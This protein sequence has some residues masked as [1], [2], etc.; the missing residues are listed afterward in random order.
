MKTKQ[1]LLAAF[2]IFCATLPALAQDIAP[3]EARRRAT[4]QRIHDRAVTLDAHV[5]IA[6]TRYATD[7]LDPGIDHPELKCDL[8]KMKRG[9]VDG[10]FLAVWTRQ[11]RLDAAGY[12][13][14]W[15]TAVQQFDAI[16]RLTDRLYPE[17]CELATSPADVLRIARSGK[18]AVMIGVENGY[19]IGTDLAKLEKLY[20]M[21]ARY[22]TLCHC[23][24]NQICDSLDA[25]QELGDKEQ[26]YHGLSAFGER[27]VAKMNRLGMM[28][29]V[30]HVSRESFYDA[31]KSSKAPVIATHVGARACFDTPRNL[32]DRQLKALAAHGGVIQIYVVGSFLKT[33]TPERQQAVSD[34]LERIGLPVKDGEPDYVNC[35]ENEIAQY[36][37]GIRVVDRQTPAAEMDDFM[38]HIDHVVAV[39]GIDHVGIGTDFD[40]GGDG[41][42]GFE[43]HSE[44]LNVTVELLRRG[45]SE[46]QVEKIWGGN[47][48]RVWR[49]VEAAAKRQPTREERIR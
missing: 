22:M 18:R 27:V 29:D 24:H 25:N 19:P 42:R 13:E 16:H 26:A 37:R 4:A 35:T 3:A 28:I 41:V 5:D 2:F 43:N 48:L 23:G 36:D 11:Q 34:L 15:R 33:P 8:V 12:R 21:G 17:R 47:L 30:S 39:A 40:G 45:Y 9:G 10:V 38:R 49:E 46:E 31:I 44:A 32:D 20:A 6:G 7:K 14:A 1:A